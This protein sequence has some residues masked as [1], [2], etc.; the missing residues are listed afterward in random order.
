MRELHEVADDLE[1][2]ASGIDFR[3][4][5]AECL[6]VNQA[7]QMSAWVRQKAQQIRQKAID[8]ERSKQWQS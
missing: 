5:W 1:Q 2:S 6:N 3:I 4:G 7:R 8:I